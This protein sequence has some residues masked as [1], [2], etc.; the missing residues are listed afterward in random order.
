MAQ[1]VLLTGAST[2]IGR[3]AA[4]YFADRGWNVAATMRNPEDAGT[5]LDRPNVKVLAL[6]VTDTECIE[7]AVAQAIEA[8]GGIDVLVNNAGYG[9]MGAFENATDAQIRRQFDVNVFGLMAVTRA[10]LPH[11]RERKQ[12]AVL[13]VAS[14]VGRMG[15]PLGSFYN[16][17]KFAV[18][19][20]SEALSYELAPHGIRVKVIEPGAIKTDFYDRSMDHAEG[21]VR[22]YD[23]FTRKFFES[24]SASVKRLGAEP[25]AVAKVVYRAATSTSKRLR[26]PAAG[27]APMLMFARKWLPD[28]IFMRAVR[29]VMS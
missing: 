23:A 5:E 22:D 15:M 9:L 7:A 8:F 4:V 3:A 11:F 13:N 25:E 17:T 29:L 6:D 24:M 21:A 14:I 16:A 18:E 2:G 26:Y 27:G 19:G 20:F 28:C 10:I 12:G 1:T